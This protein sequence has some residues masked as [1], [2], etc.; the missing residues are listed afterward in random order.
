MVTTKFQKEFWVPKIRRF[1]WKRGGRQSQLA[2]HPIMFL[3]I[4]FGFAIAALAGVKIYNYVQDSQCRTALITLKSNVDSD[5]TE[6]ASR[7]GSVMERSYTYSCDTDAIYF[8]DAAQNIPQDAFNQSAEI[9]NSLFGSTTDNLF[10]LRKGRLFAS[11]NIGQLSLRHPYYQCFNTTGVK[12]LELL[13]QGEG[14][15]VSLSHTEKYKSTGYD[16]TDYSLPEEIAVQPG[17]DKAS[18]IIGNSAEYLA[19]S[20]GLDARTAFERF[21]ETEER[22]EIDREFQKLETGTKVKIKIRPKNRKVID[23]FIYIED[24]PKACL[25]F[26]TDYEI[27]DQGEVVTAD[28]VIAWHFASIEGRQEASYFIPDIELK[29]RCK[30]LIDGVGLAENFV[31]SKEAINNDPPILALPDLFL[32]E[33]DALTTDLAP[34]ISDPDNLKKELRVSIAS[35]A[36]LRAELDG[37]ILVLTPN[38]DWNGAEK[39]YIT[40]QDQA[41]ATV[42]AITATVHPV[43]DGPVI[44]STPLTQAVQYQQ[45]NYQVTATDLEAEIEH[46]ILKYALLEYPAGMSI[47]EA[48]LISFIPQQSGE[49]TVKVQVSDRGTSAVQQYTLN[50][51]HINKAPQFAALPAVSLQGL[52]TNDNGGRDN[53]IANL[54]VFVSDDNDP[55]T[56]TYS[57]IAQTNPGLVSCYVDSINNLDCVVK[58]NEDGYSDISISAYD[59][60]YSAYTTV[61][62]TVKTVQVQQ[63]QPPPTPPPPQPAQQPQPEPQPQ[64]Q[65]QQE[66]E[67]PPPEPPQS[68]AYSTKII[69]GDNPKCDSGETIRKYWASTTCFDSV[70]CNT[71]STAAG[72][73]ADAPI[74]LYGGYHKKKCGAPELTCK[75]NTWTQVECSCTGKPVRRCEGNN[76]YDTDSC[77]TSSLI[78]YCG[79]LKCLSGRCCYKKTKENCQWWK[80]LFGQCSEWVCP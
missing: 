79:D 18:S 69:S 59:G 66:P 9:Q 6:I 42:Q 39:L 33:D 12:R 67:P 35:P 47:D 62:A 1:S 19:R 28:P 26:L 76:V 57:I 16:C 60:Q 58:K 52:G 27:E 36:N 44:T 22:V 75:A 37:F 68:S 51:Q 5:F 3:Y 41:Q 80:W 34:Y 24:I 30:E 13:I 45:Y 61:R 4:A 72:W 50:V 17:A 63:V 23:N 54:W 78:K 11:F 40:V 71:C 73:S 70:N 32:S 55:K 20:Y 8:V 7:Q 10:I 56:F 53:V 15:G 29:E 65:P 74:C 31:D 2:V 43:N 48:G 64:T 38:P 46:D 77:G 49:F 21:N 25:S 14:N